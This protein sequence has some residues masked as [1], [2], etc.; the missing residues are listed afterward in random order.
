MPFHNFLLRVQDNYACTYKC[1][2]GNGA[3]VVVEIIII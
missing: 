3:V 1:L 2:I